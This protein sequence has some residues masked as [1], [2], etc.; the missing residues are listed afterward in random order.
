MDADALAIAARALLLIILYQSAGAVGFL[1]LWGHAVPRVASQV[2]RLGAIGALCGIIV[3]LAQPPLEA[4]RMAGE[5]GGATN[6]ALL[7]LALH[8]SHGHA[9]ALQLAG[10]VLVALGLWGSRP[11][12]WGLAIALPG[13]VAAALALT[14]TG[15]TS[16]HPRRALLAP[17][18]GLH[19]LIAAFWFGAFWPLWL[20]VRAEAAPVAISVLQRFSRLA[21]W[22]VPCIA[23]AGLAMAWILIDSW[24]VLARPYG[25]LLIAKAALFAALMVLAALN[26]WRLT[27]ALR[28]GA[29]AARRT[30]QQS[31]LAE[32]LLV[33]VVL[34]ITTALTALYAPDD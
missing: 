28:S 24:T 13:A 8:S 18:L 23:L 30:L 15:H 2:R 34:T 9:H 17:L 1:A 10:L 4:A 33:A 27:P 3:V 6:A 11:R 12:A 22:L 26:R 7:R 14:L 19:L 21:L 20:L 25:R 5:P 32:Y 16:V 31:L 29:E